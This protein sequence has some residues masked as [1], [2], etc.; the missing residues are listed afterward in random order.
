LV[1]F[2]VPDIRPSLIA[3]STC[4]SFGVGKTRIYGWSVPA[5]CS[6]M[7]ALTSLA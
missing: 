2:P 1:T 4:S 6:W 3:R 5:P 7:K